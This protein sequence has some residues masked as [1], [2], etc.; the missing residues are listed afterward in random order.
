MRLTG[1][2]KVQAVLFTQWVASDDGHID[3]PA[4][5]IYNVSPIS[6]SS[7]WSNMD[8]RASMQSKVL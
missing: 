7:L 2:G 8:D 6:R 1:I 4:I 3:P 5:A